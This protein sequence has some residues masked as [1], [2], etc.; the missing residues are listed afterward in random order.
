MRICIPTAD[1]SGLES[2]INDHF[3]SS[4]F[5]TIVDTETGDCTSVPNRSPIHGHG[6]CRPLDSL[7]GQKVDAVVVG[8]I[9][10]GALEKLRAGGLKVFSTTAGQVRD[11]VAAIKSG[12]LSELSDMDACGHYGHGGGCGAH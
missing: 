5:Y 10:R 11:A 1:D 8:G 3:G 2:R 7:S 9:G 6:M 12:S 4:P